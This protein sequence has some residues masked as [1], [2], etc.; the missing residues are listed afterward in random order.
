VT[1]KKVEKQTESS[2]APLSATPPTFVHESSR[3]SS[4]SA[5]PLKEV[6]E[7]FT[8]CPSPISDITPDSDTMETNR[9]SF[10][11]SPTGAVS[12]IG[13]TLQSLVTKPKPMILG[14]PLHVPSLNIPPTSDE[15][16]DSE[17]TNS[18]DEMEQPQKKK[19]TQKKKKKKT[20]PAHYSRPSRD[21]TFE[22]NFD[23]SDP[24]RSERLV[25]RSGG[26]R[27]PTDVELL[28]SIHLEYLVN[29]DDVPSSQNEDLERALNVNATGADLV[30]LGKMIYE[31]QIEPNDV[32]KAAD[33]YRR[34]Y[35]MLLI[36]ATVIEGVGFELLYRQWSAHNSKLKKDFMADYPDEP[37]TWEKF[38][39]IVYHAK[40]DHVFKY[41]AITTFIC[42]FPAFLWTAC[43]LNYLHGG[44]GTMLR[45]L[46]RNKRKLYLELEGIIKRTH[47]VFIY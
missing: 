22:E 19:K 3:R 42:E 13:G 41:R 4:T 24:R 29:L 45:D 20:L 33:N 9:L 1:I 26:T 47:K 39:E 14:S 28:D 6:H 40:K 10:S 27:I 15:D 11:S 2:K 8:V 5:T 30:H 18:E 21:I 38:C 35:G 23:F 32:V 34:L 25:E 44:Q 46:L 16:T 17:D 7:S 37:V 12:G 31:Q 36:R 43:P